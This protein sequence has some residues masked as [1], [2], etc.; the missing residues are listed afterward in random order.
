M[1]TRLSMNEINPCLRSAGKEERKH[2]PGLK[3]KI[4]DYEL[5]YCHRG[6]MKVDFDDQSISAS[7]G[8]VI[9]I[10]PGEVHILNSSHADDVF[11][12]HF[13]F[14]Y[15]DDQEDLQRYIRSHKAL[16]LSDHTFDSDKA[17]SRILITPGLVLPRKYSVHDPEST[18]SIFLEL[19]DLFEH[20]TYTW[21]IKTKLLLLRLL[22]DTFCH[23]EDRTSF[24]P[25]S[26]PIIQYLKSNCYR[27]ITSKE[28]ANHFHY[29]HDTINRIVKK[30]TGLTIRAHLGKMRFQ[31]AKYLLETTDLTLNDIAEQCGYTDR[32]HL[33][34]S[35]QALKGR[36][37]SAYR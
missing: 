32:S 7:T 18:R 14:F 12:V 33:I 23:L 1:A 8:E 24:H 25:K 11:W 10:Q 26:D 19:N 6:Q 16:A 5:I 29:H 36:P 31:K 30:E 21:A 28:L 13:D 35:F 37:P 3:R 9:L 22:E 17:R 2:G 15:H 20:K 34:K 4:Y 27:K